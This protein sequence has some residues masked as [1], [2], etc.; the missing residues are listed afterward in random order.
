M[1]KIFLIILMVSNLTAAFSAECEDIEYFTINEVLSNGAAIGFASSNCREGTQCLYGEVGCYFGTIC[2]EQ[3][4]YL[5]PYKGID[6][7]DDKKITAPAGYCMAYEGTYR[8][9]LY[10]HQSGVYKTIPVVK[11]IR[12]K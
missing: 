2:N 8:H 7:Y 1:K 4:A 11:F 12:S 3:Q 10:F 9:E 6:Y 5:P